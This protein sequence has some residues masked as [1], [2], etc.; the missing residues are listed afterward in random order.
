MITPA[1]SK[2]AVGHRGA[3]TETGDAGQPIPAAGTSP[4]ERGLREL[5]D[6]E[7]VIRV[8]PAVVEWPTLADVERAP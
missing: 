3:T 1:S 4:I 5:R 6:A 8:A 2:S 7:P